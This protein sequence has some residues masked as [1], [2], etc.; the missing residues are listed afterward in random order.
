MASGSAP[1]VVEAAPSGTADEARAAGLRL[2]IVLLMP[3][4]KV[5]CSSA[6]EAVA[7]SVMGGGEEVGCRF[8]VPIVRLMPFDDGGIVVG[9]CSDSE[10]VASSIAGGE[11]RMGL[12]FRLPTVRLM[13][14]NDDGGT[15]TRSSSSNSDAVASSTAGGGEGVGVLFRL[16]IARL[17]PLDGTPGA[18]WLSWAC[19]N[20]NC[21]AGHDLRSDSPCLWELEPALWVLCLQQAVVMCPSVALLQ[22]Y[23]H[24]DDLDAMFAGQ[25]VAMP[26]FVSLLLPESRSS[27]LVPVSREPEKCLPGPP[28]ICPERP[29]IYQ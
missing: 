4:Y 28:C 11:E 18:S 25:K 23:T 1:S 14:F 12:R 10:T 7:S 5:G 13:P 9:S 3:L 26:V 19:E 21:S 16:P 29:S 8:R 6:S 20:V 15:A 24:S 2:L 22:S 27:A 17:M